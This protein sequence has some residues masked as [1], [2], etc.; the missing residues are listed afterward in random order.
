IQRS[1]NRLG[2]VGGGKKRLIFLVSDG[3]QNMNPMVNTTTF[4]T[5]Y[6]DPA[7]FPATGVNL[8]DAV[9]P[10][11][12]ALS[13]LGGGTINLNS[14]VNGDIERYH[15]GIGIGM[16]GAAH[17]LMN[18][19]GDKYESTLGVADLDML[20]DAMM[21]GTYL[22]TSSPRV[23]DSRRGF[24]DV[25]DHPTTERFYVNDSVQSLTIK[26]FATDKHFTS[27]SF[28]SVI[29]DG[30]PIYPKI[31][32]RPFL[33]LLHIDFNQPYWAGTFSPL[34]PAGWWEIIIFDEGR[35]P[36][37]V[38]AFVEDK[39]LHHKLTLGTGGK[40]YV[41]DPL[42]VKL[43]VRYG[44][45]PVPGAQARAVLYRPG[46]D[47]G[48]LASDAQAP[49][50][51]PSSEPGGTAA[52]AKID[53][54]V[55]QPDFYKKLLE[56]ERIIN[57][58]DQGN[59]EYTGVFNGNVNTGGYRVMVRLEDTNSV[60]AGQY[61]GWLL[62]GAF[63]DFARPN[64]IRLNETITAGAR[65]GNSQQYTLTFRPTNQFGK[66]LGPG[67]SSRIRVALDPPAQASGDL[68]DN[69]DGSYTQ[70]FTV[71]GN[72]NPQ[73]SVFV[74]DR[75]QPVKVFPARPGGWSFSLHAGLTLPR[76]NLDSL[77]DSGPYVELDLRRQ[78][79][80]HLDLELLGGY[81]GFSSDFNVLGGA[82]CLGYTL[83]NPSSAGYLR[84]AA[85]AGYYQPK[86]LDGTLGYTG[87][88]ELGYR[89][90]PRFS[91]GLNG[92]YTYLDQPEMSFLTAGLVG[93]WGF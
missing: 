60:V 86:N 42:P 89:F 71:P 72:A 74:I 53:Y 79:G 13:P 45:T 35:V 25:K 59:G 69:L 85:G 64:D 36:Y 66:K 16:T 91:L 75:Q 38:T 47:L 78:L 14:T 65:D 87:R 20:M 57:L 32:T 6:C 84:V 18:G 17:D 67:Q 11:L 7:R 34:D 68:I 62:E 48:D 73:L 49:K 41:G 40:F 29:K 26:F 55:A 23:L 8:T 2:Q 10:A 30:K 21:T 9:E 33:R 5:V 83:Q 54:L 39:R 63:Y 28:I 58:T 61:T 90:S 37:R 4:S 15:V 76:T 56:E 80:Q 22:A 27:S 52:Q 1:L 43:N 24:A 50:D 44:D 93:R 3:E 70:R 46:D 88:L 81:Y 19:S 77:Y 12:P 31:T 92:G 51:L 82:L